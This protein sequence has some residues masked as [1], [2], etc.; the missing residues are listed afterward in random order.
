ME[1][2]NSDG[3]VISFQGDLANYCRDAQLYVKEET[4][5]YLI[6]AKNLLL[7]NLQDKI[8]E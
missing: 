4:R 1:L 5:H 3:E 8:L 7:D 2:K 6:E